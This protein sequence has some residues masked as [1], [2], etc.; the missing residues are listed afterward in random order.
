MQQMC[1]LKAAYSSRHEEN[2][3][4]YLHFQSPLKFRFKSR[5]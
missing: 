5:L 2:G 1:S 3:F 4:T